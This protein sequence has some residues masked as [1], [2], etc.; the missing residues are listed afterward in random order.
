MKRYICLLLFVAVL[1]CACGAPAADNNTALTP[2]E[3]TTQPSEPI[4]ADLNDSS[5]MDMINPEI[6][7]TIDPERPMIALTFDDGPGP[8]TQRILDT[9]SANNARATF[10][11]VGNR[12]K[13]YPETMQAIVDQG[14]EIGNHSWGHAS[15]VKLDEQGVREQ[16]IWTNDEVEKNTGVRPVLLRPPYGEVND[17]VTAIVKD[18]GMPIIN[19]SIDTLD[20]KTKDPH[21][22]YDAIMGSVTNGCIILCHDIYE[23]T[24]EAMETVI[25]DLVKAGYQ[26]VMVSE[27][28]TLLEG[29]AIAGTV[30]RSVN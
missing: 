13:S 3:Y 26:L 21:K 16:L 18:V 27:M 28:L 14:S 8:Y 22:T 11:I 1:L 6:I 20:W 30:Y 12:V 7:S 4:S 10:F 23:E 9:L 2:G 5:A 25:P 19:W 15:L 17:S 29:G 24:A